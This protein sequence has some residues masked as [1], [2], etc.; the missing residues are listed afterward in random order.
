MYNNPIDDPSEKH[1]ITHLD[2]ENFEK[3]MNLVL[4]D[5]LKEFWL[6]YN[7][8]SPFNNKFGDDGYIASFEILDIAEDHPRAYM[9]VKRFIL[10]NRKTI[11]GEDESG[12]EDRLS[13]PLH[14]MPFAHDIT[15][16]LLFVSLGS[17]DLGSVFRTFWDESEAILISDNFVDF[18]NHLES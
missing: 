1:P 8:T 2:I 6:Q 7:G 17:K 18:I 9:S 16:S 5:F 12:E 10:T 13:S 4:P 14:F 15:G 11:A 3:E